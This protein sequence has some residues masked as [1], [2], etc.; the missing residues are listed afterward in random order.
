MTTIPLTSKVLT[1][2][3]IA[4]TDEKLD[5]AVST[6]RRKAQKNGMSIKVKV[7]SKYARRVTLI[8]PFLGKVSR[9]N[10]YA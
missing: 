1:V 8:H 9:I 7:L 2:A 5:K 6:L 10:V 4:W 3:G